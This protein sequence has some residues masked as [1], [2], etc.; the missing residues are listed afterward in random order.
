MAS[1]A[2]T[3]GAVRGARTA[4][5]SRS[6]PD[7]GVALLILL[8]VPVALYGLAF[9][10]VPSLNPEFHA[11]LAGMP[12]FARAH[13]LGAGVALLIGGFQFSARLRRARPVLH[14]WLGRGY[15]AAVL[16]GGVGGLG[17]ATISHGGPPTH[18]G[19]GM[20]AVL[21]LYSA[22][23][24]YRAIRAGDVSTHRTWMIRNFALTFA[25]VTLRFELGVFTGLLGWGFDEA[26]TTIAWLAWVPNLIVA[27][28]WL[29]RR[30]SA[31]AD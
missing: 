29:M 12:W 26:Y 23:Q 4:G 1:H 15:L 28:W 8:S 5:S 18:V 27:E 9:S 22:I 2:V 7:W 10:F 3:P 21:W 24:A 6:A 31:T 17:I 30:G 11:R 25:A 16:V 13:F 14:R 20:L 19:F